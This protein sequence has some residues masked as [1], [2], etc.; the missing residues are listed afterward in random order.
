MTTKKEEIAMLWGV[1]TGAIAVQGCDEILKAQMLMN[2]WVQ[3]KLD[4][5]NEQ[6]SES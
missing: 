4:E 3:E 5:E 1:I 2:D 6:T